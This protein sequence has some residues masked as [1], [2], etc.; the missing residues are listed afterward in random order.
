[1]PVKPP[2]PPNVL[3]TVFPN[4]RLTMD[5]VA[6]DNALR[7]QGI[8]LMHFRAMRCPGGLIDINDIRRPHEDH[9]NCSNG[10]LYIYQGIVTTLV[11][12][13][14][15]DPKLIDV[16]LINGSSV[17]TTFPRNYNAPDQDKM[18]YVLPYD[19]FYLCDPKILVATWQLSK[20]SNLPSDRYTFPVECVQNIVDSR[21]ATY[22]PD[23]YDIQNGQIFW[24]PG[25]GP[26]P[27][28]IYT[29]W[30][31]YRPFWYVKML[32]HEIRVV[33][34]K[35]YVTGQASVN[36]MP[37]SAIL[38]RENV[39]HNEEVNPDAPETPRSRAHPEDGGF[40]AR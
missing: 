25:L 37:F 29:V 6:F 10:F 14:S 3:G 28:T 15:V 23:T 1:M 40:G 27:G 17:Q 13:N 9:A 33:G 8:P 19:R 11:T 22:S 18:V 24:K 36:R 16:G 7:N 2:S 26:E 30:Y 4:D 39:F 12:A 21:L 20:R 5:P 34:N 32:M 31:E 38:T 35:D